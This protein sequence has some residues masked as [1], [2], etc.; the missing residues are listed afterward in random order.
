MLIAPTPSCS[1]GGRRPW[2]RST[3]YKKRFGEH[4]WTTKGG[5]P[6]PADAPADEKVEKEKEKR[7]KNSS[8]WFLSR[9][10]KSV[11]L[12]LLQTQFLSYRRNDSTRLY[13][14]FLKILA[15]T[16]SILLFF[17][18]FS[19]GR[20]SPLRRKLS[21]IKSQSRSFAV[22]CV[23]DGWRR[24]SAAIAILIAH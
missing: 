2:V 9:Y 21:A 24:G 13:L 3:I 22:G 16:M 23:M 11:L 7:K 8:I 5:R 14:F 18:F 10:G 6:T 19:P 17:I 20:E 15:P 4:P 1:L 12:M